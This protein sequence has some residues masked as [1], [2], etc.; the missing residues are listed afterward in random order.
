MDNKNLCAGI[1]ILDLFASFSPH[2]DRMTKLTS[3]SRSLLNKK[4]IFSL[5]CDFSSPSCPKTAIEKLKG[6]QKGR[7]TINGMG[8]SRNGVNRRED[9]IFTNIRYRFS[10]AFQRLRIRLYGYIR[11]IKNLLGQYPTV[12]G[13]PGARGSEGERT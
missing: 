10:A 2:D 12:L 1:T 6:T 13:D 11:Y 8:Q 9:E 3:L 4:V 7:L 5:T